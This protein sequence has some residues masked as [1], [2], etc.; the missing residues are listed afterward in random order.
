MNS[1]AFA[2]AIA[3][4]TV[5]ISAASSPAFAK[6]QGNFGAAKVT[7]DAKTERYCFKEVVTGSHIP[8]TE[9]RSKDAWAQ[10]GLTIRHKPAVQL[11]Q[12]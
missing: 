10:A 4:A 3:A 12:R 7:Y 2:A 1:I 9:C 5:A 8:V 11:A 6:S